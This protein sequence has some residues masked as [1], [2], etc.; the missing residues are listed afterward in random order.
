MYTGMNA[1]YVSRL[2]TNLMRLKSGCK[3]QCF[4]SILLL[5]VKRAVSLLQPKTSSWR[6]C[7]S[8]NPLNAQQTHRS[9]QINYRSTLCL[10]WWKMR[11]CVLHDASREQST[12]APV[13][14]E[15]RDPF[16]IA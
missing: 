7:E 8:R 12:H 2:K 3:G 16:Q 9:K 5:I 14:T 1:G 4:S 11:G 13:Q 10:L 6:G 15:L